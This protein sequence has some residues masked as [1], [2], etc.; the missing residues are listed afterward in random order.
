[1][2]LDRHINSG[3]QRYFCRELGEFIDVVPPQQRIDDNWYQ[4]TAD[5]VYQNIYGIEKEKPEYVVILAGD[6]VYKMDY[7]KMV[8]RHIETQADITVAA[9]TIPCSEAAGTFG[10]M[11]VDSDWRAQGFQEKPLSPT[12]IPHQTENC[13]AS[14][15]IYVFTARFL[16]E[17]LC[18]DAN[19]L[20]SRRDFGG[21]V[22]PE[23]IDSNRVFAYLFDFQSELDGSENTPESQSRKNR[24]YW[25]DVGKIASYYEANMDLIAV[26]PKLNLYDSL[27][28][29]RTYHP[30]LPPAKFVFSEP[31]RQGCAVDSIVGQGVIISGGQVN[32]SVLGHS[33]RINSY[34]KVE[35]S[36]LF[37]DVVIGRGAKIRRGIIDRGVQIPT[38][39]EIGFDPEDDR[40]RGFHVTDEGITVIV[41]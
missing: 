30:D 24:P 29:I 1:M 6:H 31:Q 19:K 28:P 8:R 4:G 41:S 5:A 32:H 15:G 12:P 9:M 17:Q 40:R 11:E 37:A 39:M 33:V 20:E 34:A 21:N 3:W 25:R 23:S 2:S 38:G 27:W 26:E 13:L 35:D 10:V 7:Q 22:I 18:R 16:F 36:I 14:M